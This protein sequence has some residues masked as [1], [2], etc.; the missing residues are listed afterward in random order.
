[1][2]ESKLINSVGELLAHAKVMETEAYECY[3]DLAEQMDVHNNTEVA[4]LFKKIAAE[5]K[6]HID[7]VNARAGDDKLPH[8][9]PWEFKAFETE[10]HGLTGAR[11][12]HYMMTPYHALELALRAEERSYAF[13]T[14]VCETAKDEQVLAMAREL[15]EEERHH[16]ALIKEWLD[17]EPKPEENWDEDPDPPVLPT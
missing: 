8:I 11:E 10:S 6:K 17:K 4:E 1:M 9:A 7:K 3:L 13:F 16:V 14:Q 15:Q 5:E 2:P 12:V